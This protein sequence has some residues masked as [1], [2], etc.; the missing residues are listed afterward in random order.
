MK[1]GVLYRLTKPT[2]GI[3]SSEANHK[4]PVTIPCGAVIVLIEY[5]EDGKFVDVE[6]EGKQVRIFTLD[7]QS[8]GE[9][10]LARG[11]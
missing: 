3:L 5:A 9:M 8:R 7:L 11:A 1:I 4:I 10:I 2:L 6:W